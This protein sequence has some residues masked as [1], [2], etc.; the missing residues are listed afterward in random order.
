M[1]E[2]GRRNGLQ[3]G[4]ARLVSLAAVL[5][6]A[7]CAAA[8][9]PL[10]VAPHEANAAALAQCLARSWEGEGFGVQVL[11]DGVGWR[12][13]AF[14]M[15][16]SIRAAGRVPPRLVAELQPGPDGVSRASLFAAPTLFGARRVTEWFA[17][18]VAEC[19]IGAARP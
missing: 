18:R 6:A 12:V 7:G 13:E 19:E 9:L 11:A 8:P 5:V 2:L 16:P 10:V 14:G 17:S 1:G 15:P 3:G 4:T